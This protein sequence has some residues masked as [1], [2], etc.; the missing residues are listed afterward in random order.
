MAA[1]FEP[2][3]ASFLEKMYEKVGP[4]TYK[5]PLSRFHAITI[6]A[7]QT[8]SKKWDKIRK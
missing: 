8:E 5:D 4:V 2:M 3:G 6:G 7:D 1:E